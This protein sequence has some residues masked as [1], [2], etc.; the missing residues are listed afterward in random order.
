MLLSSWQE[1]RVDPASVLNGESGGLAT[2]PELWI[3]S[4]ATTATA[5]NGRA[6]AV[7]RIVRTPRTLELLVDGSPRLYALLTEHA[8]RSLSLCLRPERF[9]P[10][11]RGPGWTAHRRGEAVLFQRETSD[12]SM[13][14]IR[15]GDRRLLLTLCLPDNNRARCLISF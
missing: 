3:P 1:D 15:T 4:G 14:L 13:L 11:L 10:F 8:Q 7:V 5:S 2:I 12:A 9:L 6:C